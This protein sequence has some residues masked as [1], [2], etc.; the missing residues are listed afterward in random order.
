LRR[1]GEWRTERRQIPRVS[2]HPL[3]TLR[4]DASEACPLPIDHVRHVA[5]LAQAGAGSRS[6]AR[7]TFATSSRNSTFGT[8]ADFVDNRPNVGTELGQRLGQSKEF[9]TR[10]D[11]A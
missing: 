2:A 5:S 10:P 4:E 7:A 8:G 9:H 11:R 3:E 6:S 1:S